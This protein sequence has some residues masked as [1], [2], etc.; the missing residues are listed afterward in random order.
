MITINIKKKYLKTLCVEMNRII[1]S[2]T[3]IAN[4]NIVD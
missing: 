1:I 4:I 2:Q 3:I